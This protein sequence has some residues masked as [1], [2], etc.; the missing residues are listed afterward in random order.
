M[1]NVVISKFDV[2]SEAY[3]AF[4][5]LKADPVSAS[6]RI[7]Q[8]TLV[9]REGGEYRTVDAFNDGRYSDD[10]WAGGFLGMLIGILGG[11]LG[12]LLGGGI[13]FLAGSAKDGRDAKKDMSLLECVIADVGEDCTFLAVFAEET[14]PAMLNSKLSRFSQTTTRY[15]AAEL[16][17]ELQE[18][19]DLEREM[20]R[21]AKAELRDRKKAERKA[22]VEANRG[23]FRN[24]KV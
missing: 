18:A 24:N 6:C 22:R 5:M 14:E 20:T 3:Q 19:K 10:T 17:A 21:K 23:R 15:D 8:V 12:V 9:R 13:G 2:E 16:M 1:Q 11:P 4:S 7:S